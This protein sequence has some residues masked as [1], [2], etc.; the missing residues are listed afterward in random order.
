MVAEL[1][2]LMDDIAAVHHRQSTGL[3]LDFVTNTTA[4]GGAAA[5]QGS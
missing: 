1:M 4:G 2:K 5:A 3:E